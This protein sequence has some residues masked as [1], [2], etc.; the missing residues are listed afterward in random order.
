MIAQYSAQTIVWYHRV[1][2]YTVHPHRRMVN[3]VTAPFREIISHAGAIAKLIVL[4]P[5]FAVFCEFNRKLQ[6]IVVKTLKPVLCSSHMRRFQI[7]KKTLAVLQLFTTYNLSIFFTPVKSPWTIPL[8]PWK[9]LVLKRS[10]IT[11][12][13]MS[14]HNP[15]IHPLSCLMSNVQC[16][17]YV[18]ICRRTW[19]LFSTLPPPTH[20]GPGLC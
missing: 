15:C 10:M 4:S 13:H 19:Q 17:M 18:D 2:I 8:K 12:A 20:P 6:F 16:N 1:E 7:W 11:S 14:L 9:H 3:L 5:S